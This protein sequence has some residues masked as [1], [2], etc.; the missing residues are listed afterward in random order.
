MPPATLA[1]NEARNT[2]WDC[3]IVGGGPAGLAA[4]LL[5]G[6]A[7]RPVL[8]LDSGEY[9]NAS[10][11]HLHGFPTR[12][13]C[14]PALLRATAHEE[15]RAYPTV[16][17]RSGLAVEARQQAG[18]FAVT[19]QDQSGQRVLHSRKLLLATG[20]A[21]EV[22]GLPGLDAIYGL[23][24]WHCPYCDGYERQDQPLAV[25]GPPAQG[26]ALALEASG[27]SGNVVYCSGGDRLEPREHERLS[28]V[29]IRVRESPV[30]TL[31]L[32]GGRLRGLRLADGHVITCTAL[33]LAM[34]FRQRSNLAQQLGCSLTAGGLVQ[35]NA[36]GRT[37][38]EGLYVAGD[39]ASSLHLALIAAAQGSHAA[40][41]ANTAL[42]R[43]D[44]KARR[45]DAP[46]SYR[47]AGD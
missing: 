21:D 42:L 17:T 14:P 19:V 27:W 18:G 13:G 25:Y 29:G 36:A 11:H 40:F 45:Q 4:A 41:A 35:A 12:D 44:L 26:V 10:A 34:R 37:G 8:L 32:E 24:A 47:A 5:L 20:V 6:R 43:E 2:G 9:R 22:P 15:L 38:V 28:S 30:Q 46:P 7:R 33:L 16:V 1:Q 31:M 23:D 3:I 39:A